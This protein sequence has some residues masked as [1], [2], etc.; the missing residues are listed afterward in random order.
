MQTIAAAESRAV[1]SLLEIRQQQVVIQQF[2]LSCGAAA[3]A[4]PLRYQFGDAVTEHGIAIA[5]VRRDDYLTDPDLL[6]QQQGFSLLD[7]KRY[8]QH[9]GYD[10]VGYSGLTLEDLMQRAPVM[11]PINLHGY[12]HFVIFRV[13]VNERV[14]L[15]DPAWGNRNMS[16]DGF[17]RA[18]LQQEQ[19]DGIGFIVV[20]R[21]PALHKNRLAPR[22]DDFVL[23]E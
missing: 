11:V 4:T 7:L 15:A 1:R 2:D 19:V 6:R 3:L 22:A 23:F 13:A 9:R 5:M 12:Q 8:V 20:Q 10:G 17:M 18:W 16:I 14:V 21:D